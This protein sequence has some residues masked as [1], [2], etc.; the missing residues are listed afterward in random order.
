MV[1]TSTMAINV[2]GQYDKDRY[3]AEPK[4][5]DLGLMQM[6][7]DVEKMFIEY[8][9]LFDLDPEQAGDLLEGDEN[10]RTCGKP[11]QHGVRNEVEQCSQTGQAHRNLEHSDDQRHEEGEFQVKSRI[12]LGQGAE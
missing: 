10:R 6:G 4:G 9:R 11:E 5:D 12:R 8:A 7:D 2:H 1:P 3:D